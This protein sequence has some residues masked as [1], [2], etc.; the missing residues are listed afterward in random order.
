[1]LDTQPS[2][3]A[4]PKTAA[5]K[6]AAPKTKAT[7]NT[8]NE[9]RRCRYLTVRGLQCDSTALRGHNFCHTHSNFRHP[10]LPPKGSKIVMPLLEDHSSI[11]LVLSQIAHGLLSGAI[12]KDT[13]CALAYTCQV[14]TC[15][16]PRPVAP[17]SKPADQP[18][19]PQQPVA[20]VTVSPDGEPLGPDEP[21]RAPGGAP[22][23]WSFDKFLLDQHCQ[24]LNLP[25]VTRPEDLPPSGWLTEE[26]MKERKRD[27]QGFFDD[28]HENIRNVHQQADLLG[29]LPPIETRPCAFSQC[30]GP[31]S[32]K[33]CNDCKRELKEHAERL[34]LKASGPDPAILD[35]LNASTEPAN[36]AV[37]NADRG[38]PSAEWGTPN[39]VLLPAPGSSLPAPGSTLDIKLNTS[40]N[41]L[42]PNT[43]IPRSQPG[44]TPSRRPRCSGKPHLRSS[45]PLPLLSFD[46][47]STRYFASASGTGASAQELSST[48]LTPQRPSAPFFME[49]SCKVVRPSRVQR[50]T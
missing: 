42:I 10:E 20:E 35:T 5:P 38:T 3:P 40:P 27:P 6:T 26:E 50:K 13:A 18:T 2:S 11:Q 15:T 34:E 23:T 48:L 30:S 36:V 43:R 24:L 37:P 46:E 19:P 49:P 4:A 47:R 17:R 29:L 25:P 14:A 21:Y 9:N 1:M 45:E 44:G 39:A 41:P 28:L 32:P 7:N 22:P 8:P 33:P 31:G 16:L 12:D